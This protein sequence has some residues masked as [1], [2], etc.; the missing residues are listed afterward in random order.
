M[1]KDSTDCNIIGSMMVIHLCR[2]I[3]S[4]LPSNNWVFQLQNPS[5]HVFFLGHS[6]CLTWFL[7]KAELEVK[8]YVLLLYW[9]V[10]FQGGGI[11]KREVK[12]VEPMQSFHLSPVET[13]S[14][15]ANEL[16]HR[17]VSHGGEKGK[18]FIHQLLF[19]PGP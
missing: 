11:R 5:L 18:E 8:S 16:H 9:K 3:L 17:V 12:Q 10:Q 1:I 4:L 13:F 15:R 2:K 19:S 7:Q 6:K 14:G